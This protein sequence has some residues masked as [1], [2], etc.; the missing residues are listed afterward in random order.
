VRGG[1]LSNDNEQEGQESFEEMFLESLETS[2]S[3]DKIV[4]ESLGYLCTRIDLLDEA[5]PGWGDSVA[6][7][8]KEGE[9]IPHVD[10]SF[11]IPWKNSTY[12]KELLL[13]RHRR[14]N[15]VG[16]VQFKDE[17]AMEERIDEEYPEDIDTFIL[18][19][20]DESEGTCEGGRAWKGRREIDHDA[21]IRGHESPHGSHNGNG[22]PYKTEN[23]C[24]LFEV[25]V[26]VGF[27]YDLQRINRFV[28]SEVFSVLNPHQIWEPRKHGWYSFCEENQVRRKTKEQLRRLPPLGYDLNQW[29]E[30]DKA[31][32]HWA[33][34]DYR[35]RLGARALKWKKENKE[36][37]E[38]KEEI[39]KII[40]DGL[41]Y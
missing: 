39:G 18:A 40:V 1:Q 5:F 11:N 28:S 4:R 21:P 36:N 41:L 13:K 38:N 33:D 2:F 10:T 35:K 3:F 12:A 14:K 26:E 32:F 22:L 19:C 24:T 16:N 34:I 6:Y 25:Y 31:S 29:D 27:P 17:E 8:R 9:P 23:E 20:V 7:Y 37:K 30:G 15:P